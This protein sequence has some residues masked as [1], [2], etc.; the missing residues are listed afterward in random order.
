MFLLFCLR[1]HLTL[2][3]DPLTLGNSA[4]TEKQLPPEKIYRAAFLKN[5]FAD[6]IL[7]AREKPLNQV[8]CALQPT[9]LGPFRPLN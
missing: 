7:K 3:L 8:C 4:Q 9:V 5:R 6:I 1:W 2:D